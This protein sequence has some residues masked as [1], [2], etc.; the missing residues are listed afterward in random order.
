MNVHSDL[1]VSH[2]NVRDV[3]PLYYQIRETATNGPCVVKG[4]QPLSF[5]I[6][7]VFLPWSLASPLPF[8]LSFRCRASFQP[9]L[10]SPENI[11]F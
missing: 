8:P 10:I 11:P 5:A 9:T 2:F 3:V 6:L 4:V 7:S 1:G